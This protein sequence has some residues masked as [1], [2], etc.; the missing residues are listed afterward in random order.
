MRTATK[1][2]HKAYKKLLKPTRITVEWR[3]NIEKLLKT[4]ENMPKT[5]QNIMKHA[6]SCPRIHEDSA[7]NNKHNV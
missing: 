6:K 2:L 7:K 5:I 1:P 4:L 3:T